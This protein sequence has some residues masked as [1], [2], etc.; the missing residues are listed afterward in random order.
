MLMLIISSSAMHV[1]VL[2]RCIFWYKMDEREAS[3]QP[4]SR[5]EG[6]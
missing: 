4:L 1:V 2:K 5:G 3:P 6:L